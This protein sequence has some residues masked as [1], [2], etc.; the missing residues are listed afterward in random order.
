MLDTCLA[1]RGFRDARL[2]A[3]FVESFATSTIRWRLKVQKLNN[4]ASFSILKASYF[5]MF[6][7]I[8]RRSESQRPATS[9]TA[10][11]VGCDK[12]LGEIAYEKRFRWRNGG[13]HNP[14]IQFNSCGKPYG[15]CFPG[16]VVIILRYTIHVNGAHNAGEADN[17]TGAEE[18]GD[19]NALA[20]WQ[21]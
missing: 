12:E 14:D 1:G 8:L 3:F 15:I 13:A 11:M 20:D 16:Y 10:V 18:H 19:N 7:Y 2:K 9:A 5:R 21:V 17:Q 6:E 4:V